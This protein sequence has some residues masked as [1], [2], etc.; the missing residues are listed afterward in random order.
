MAELRDYQRE[1]IDDF[2]CLVAVGARSVLVTTP[3][4][5]GKTVIVSATVARTVAAR[6]LGLVLG[7]RCQ[8]ID[9]TVRKLCDD[10][11]REGISA[12]ATCEARTTRRFRLGARWR[13]PARG[14]RHR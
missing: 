6:Q 8:I 12:G 4:G 14:A 2:E 3:T 9:R 7:N 1:T 5:S 13:S 10:R 11:Q